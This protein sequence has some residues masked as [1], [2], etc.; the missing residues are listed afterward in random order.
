[1]HLL[2]KQQHHH[3]HHQP[4]SNEIETLFSYLI[5][6]PLEAHSRRTLILGSTTEPIKIEHF[7]HCLQNWSYIFPSFGHNKYLPIGT[8]IHMTVQQSL[9]P[10]TPWSLHC[11]YAKKS[12][13]IACT[14]FPVHP[15]II[16]S[17]Q[18]NNQTHITNI[19]GKLKT[20]SSS[21]YIFI[22]IIIKQQLIY[23]KK[24]FRYMHEFI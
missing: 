9:K 17:I 16:H 1:M 24:I 5:K 13:R 12:H 2:F 3:H 20:C 4:K 14:L 11:Q 6:H 15:P 19:W 18:L 21:N 10:S 7:I 8:H 22:Y 23:G